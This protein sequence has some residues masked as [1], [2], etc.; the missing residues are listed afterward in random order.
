MSEEKR[1]KKIMLLHF[2]DEEGVRLKEMV[3]QI[4][5]QKRVSQQEYVREAIREKIERDAL[6]G[7][8]YQD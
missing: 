7:R 8:A 6:E 2:Y 3:Y 1:Q 5:H 4:S